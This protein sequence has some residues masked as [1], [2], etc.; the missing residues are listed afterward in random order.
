MNRKYLLALDCDGVLT[1]N[2]YSILENGERFCSFNFADIMGLNHLDRTL[3]TVA[4]I[5]GEANTCLEYFSAKCKI[6]EVI[7]N[8]KNKKE[9]V[10]ALSRKYA[11]DI[12]DIIFIGNDVNDKGAMDIAGFSFCPSDAHELCRISVDKILPIKGGDG[13]ARY[14]CDNIKYLLANRKKKNKIAVNYTLSRMRDKI[15]ADLYELMINVYEKKGTMYIFGNGGSASDSS[16]IAAELVNYLEKD[17]APYPAVSLIS[18]QSVIS[19]ISN[20]R[21][22]EEVFERQILALAKEGD[23]VMG[24]TT[25]GRS[26]NVSRGLEAAKRKG[27]F[28]CL[29]TSHKCPV[30]TLNISD[31]TYM[32]DFSS[33]LEIQQDHQSFYHNLCGMIERYMLKL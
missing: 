11:I 22:F 17:R 13:V 30:E 8:C 28:T 4:V 12:D 16:H 23:L 14:F 27:A 19:S 26:I 5:S 6:D 25:S 33:T 15:L 9:A 21:S 32:S 2:R 3:F 10:V 18:D 31:I 1:N 29:L 20:D 7:T 24:I